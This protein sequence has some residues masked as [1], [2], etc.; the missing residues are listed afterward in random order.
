MSGARTWR[1]RARAALVRLGLAVATALFCM[2]L[3]FGIGWT[4]ATLW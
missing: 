2:L 4:A 3:V 1:H